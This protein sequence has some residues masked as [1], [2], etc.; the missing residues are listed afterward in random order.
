M[1]KRTLTALALTV[2]ALAL[3]AFG[4]PASDDWGQPAENV[5]SVQMEDGSII[6]LMWGTAPGGT[7]TALP[8][9]PTDFNLPVELP[10][11]LLA[12]LPSNVRDRIEGRVAYQDPEWDCAMEIGGPWKSGTTISGRGGISCVGSVISHTRVTVE[13]E[14]VNT[15]IKYYNS[16]WKTWKSHGKTI[17][18]SCSTGTYIYQNTV[19]VSARF[20][21]GDP[22]RYWADYQNAQF[23]C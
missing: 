19:N 12:Q 21:N 20:N 18:A 3:M 13:L 23:T 6:A 9:G 8:D 11:S 17:S 16:R 2:L 7:R 14:R 4:P 5:V 22:T 15:R 10:E 1:L